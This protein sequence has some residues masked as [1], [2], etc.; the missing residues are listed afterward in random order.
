M[1]SPQCCG[2]G[3]RLFALAAL[4]ALI[5]VPGCCCGTMQ[6]AKPKTQKPGPA[7]AGKAAAHHIDLPQVEQRPGTAIVILVDTSGSMA[8]V[9][10]DAD[11]T[12][13]PKNQIAAR[14]LHGIVDYTTQWKK[15]H[16]GSHLQLAI[17]NFSSRVNEVLPMGEFDGKKAEAA[18]AR[19]PGPNGGTAIGLAIEEG[20]KALY[21]S[22][23]T[24][25]FIVCVTDGE[26]TA[27]ISPDVAARQL[28]AQTGGA[29]KLN[30][31]AFDTSANL[32]GFVG[33]VNGHVVE[34]ADGGKLQA[35]LATIYQK[36]I[37]A[38]APDDAAK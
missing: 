20:Y 19:I 23:C 1:S 8:Q 17:Y 6:S 34:A 26:N 36:R 16:A 10:P 2:A 12:L 30:F 29:V 18:L 37:L 14:A 25:K 38:E 35:E 3:T 7:D 9:V 24:R 27:G 4:L 21:R 15:D 33:A 31:V 5:A 22:G 28:H 32:F 11:R 13:K